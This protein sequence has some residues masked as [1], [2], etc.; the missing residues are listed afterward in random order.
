MKIPKT[1][2]LSLISG[3]IM[4]RRFFSVFSAHCFSWAG[5][6]YRWRPWTCWLVWVPACVPFTLGTELCYL[7]WLSHASQWG[8]VSGGFF[9]SAPAQPLNVVP[10][11]SWMTTRI[12]LKVLKTCWGHGRAWSASKEGTLCGVGVCRVLSSGSDLI[13]HSLCPMRL[14]EGGWIIHGQALLSLMML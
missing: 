7:S 10:T 11:V 2:S 1:S 4:L 14:S 13:I 6:R 12:Y 9:L 3:E 8:F 5:A